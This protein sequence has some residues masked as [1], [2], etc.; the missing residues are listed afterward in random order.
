[1]SLATP[2]VALDF[3]TRADALR[4]VE[5]LPGADFF[6]VGLELFTAEGPGLVT[7]LKE[8]GKRVF[9]D[10]K[11][12]DIPNTVGGAV[13][14]AAALEVDLL[15]IHIAGGRAMLRAAAQAADRAEVRPRIMGVTALT[16]LGQGDLA[17]VWGRDSLIMAD[18]VG[19]L[20]AAA[21]ESGLDGVV[22][23]VHE[24]PRIKQEHPSLLIL[25]PG[26]R[27][28]GDSAGDQARVAT[29]AEAARSGADYLVIGRTVTAAPDPAAAYDRVLSELSVAP[30]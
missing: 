4:L 14:S 11:F 16:S 21:V 2:I 30:V 26:I 12:H 13:R 8:R 1:M 27:L 7:A 24:V 10:L 23:S 15:T 6:K 20:A 28:A 22:A 29:P 18:E 17:G 19:R 5:T 25:T 3:S 9:L